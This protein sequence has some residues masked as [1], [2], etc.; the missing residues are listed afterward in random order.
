MKK[1][2]L[3]N[4]E[5]DLALANWDAHY[6]PPLSA[7]QMAADLALLPV[8][9]AESGASVLAPSAYNLAYLKELQQLL[10]IEVSL[11]TEA[12]AFSDVTSVMPWGWN[13]TVRKKMASLGVAE[14]VLP[15]VEKL[16][17]LRERSHR[18]QAVDLL[19]RLQMAGV[20]G[21]ESFYLQDME[22]CRAFVESGDAC[23]LKAPWSGS[24]KG[25][26]W[27]K[28]VF[29]PLIAGWCARLIDQQGG[30]VGEP[31]YAKRMDFA[32]EF[33]SD[34]SGCVS[35]VGYSLFGTTDSGAYSDN[36]LMSDSDF[37][38]LVAGYVGADALPQL[39]ARLKKELALRY[40]NHYE[41]YLGVDMMVI[42]GNGSFLI[43][44][45]VEVNLRMNMGVL[46]RLFYQRYVVEG[47]TGRFHIAYTSYEGEALRSHETKMQ[48]S[49]LVVR[50]GRIVSGYLSLVPVHKRSRY[51]AWVE[52]DE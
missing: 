38:A 15:S 9:Y 34:G 1:L 30:V 43:H 25:L 49:P 19:P 16:H 29:T 11:M 22:A 21:G 13:L 2:Y 32:L 35:F 42:D 24:G 4:P 5:H 46:T 40:G 26:N 33:R 20:C 37:E 31:I 39:R 17:V 36:R 27:C 10:P 3:F 52:I 45:C 12:E 8:W 47:H 6:M 18:R 48:E 51:L 44:P 50:E 14:A 7:R 41:G 28:G 23:L